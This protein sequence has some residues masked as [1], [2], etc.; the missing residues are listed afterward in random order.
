M[1]VLFTKMHG[2]G[3]DYIYI[4]RIRNKYLNLTNDILPRVSRYLSNR[5]FGVGADGV[6]LI[7]SSNVA[8]FKMRIFNS[9]GSEAEMCGNGIRCFAKY[10]YD[11]KL[12]TK[13]VFNIET[14]AG[15]KNVKILKS[16]EGLVQEVEVNMGKPKIEKDLK[17]NVFNKMITLTK[18]NIGN[19]H[20][21]IF[22]RNLDNLNIEKYG[23]IIENNKNFPN[24]TNVEFVEILDRNLIKLRVWERGSKETYACGTGACATVAT[25]VYK[26][27]CDKKVKVLLKGG[28]LN[29]S[30]KKDDIYMRGIATNVFS[31]II[32]IE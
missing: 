4:D 12:T 15:I 1:K 32:D 16:K 26:D 23:S 24:R 27:L 17:I 5:H 8:D 13:E 14:L 21:I 3:N 18:V 20:A 19:P 9:D 25:C 30:Y 28:E 29:I 2:L 22:A 6:I 11:N 10:V 31:G 7:E